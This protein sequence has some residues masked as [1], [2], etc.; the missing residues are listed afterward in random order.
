MGKIKDI[1]L[2]RREE[3]IKTLRE[4]VS[5]LEQNNLDAAALRDKQ[6]EADALIYELNELLAKV[7]NEMLELREAKDAYENERRKFVKL[8]VEYKKKMEKFFKSLG[9]K[10]GNDG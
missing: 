2:K 6:I 4:R 8:N 10:E 9:G 1:R 7:S 3:L 5:E